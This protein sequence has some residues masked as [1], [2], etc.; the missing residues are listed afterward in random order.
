MGSTLKLRDKE[1]GCSDAIAGAPTMHGGEVGIPH[2]VAVL[3]AMDI[4]GLK[5]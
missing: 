4:F 1:R 3:R 5:G 2:T